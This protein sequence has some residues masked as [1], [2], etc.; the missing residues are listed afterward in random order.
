[1]MG[2]LL[3]LVLSYSLCGLYIYFAR[4][5]RILDRPNERSAH[6]DPTPHGGGLPLLLA[7]CVGMAVTAPWGFD[8]WLLLAASL[9]LMGVGM[10]DDF[11]GLSVALRFSLYT[12]VGVS[13]AAILLRSSDS[14]LTP[15]GLIVVSGF[16]FAIVWAINLYNFMDGIDGIAAAQCVLACTGAALLV[17]E[18]PLQGQYAL[19]CLLLAAS[20]LG[21]MLWNWAP[22]RLFM[23]DAGSIPT[24]Y[25]LAA[26]AGYGAIHE[27]VSFACWLVLLAVFITDATWTLAWRIITGQKF[28]QAHSLH[29]YQRLS[30]HWGSHRAVVLLLLGV[31]T[32]WLFPI[33]WAVKQWPDGTV[34]LVILAYIPLLLGMAKVTKLT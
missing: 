12:L 2:L 25:L 17:R 23:G 14:L 30:R 31:G 10:V 15:V 21:F 19:F 27:V 13:S 4:R 28:T 8:Y 32:L 33:A 11:R 18:G 1:M 22:A 5:W 6:R 24:G 29:G 34:Y 16:A 7:L 20:Q 26:L 9:F 3:A